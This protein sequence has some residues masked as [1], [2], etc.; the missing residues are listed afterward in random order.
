[1]AEGRTFIAQQQRLIVEAE[2]DGEDATGTFC[3]LEKFLILQQ[4]RE[5]AQSQLKDA[6]SY[7][8][9]MQ[10]E[11]ETAR[12]EAEKAKAQAAEYA[13]LLANLNASGDLQT[14]D[15]ISRRSGDR[16]GARA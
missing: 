8:E 15:R 13:S 11:L 10:S 1:V 2:R 5:T 14:S 4:S 6:Q 7:L 16:P 9:G 12:Q 3:V